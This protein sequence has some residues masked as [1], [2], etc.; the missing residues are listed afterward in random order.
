MIY[1][2]PFVKLHFL[3]NASND[4]SADHVNPLQC[5]IPGDEMSS[6]RNVVKFRLIVISLRPFLLFH[7]YSQRPLEYFFHSPLHFVIVCFL[8]Q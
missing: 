6:D 3:F 7:R 1:R 5:E 4:P 2:K 8:L